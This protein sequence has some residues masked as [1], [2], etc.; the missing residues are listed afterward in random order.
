MALANF[1]ETS[2]SRVGEVWEVPVMIFTVGGTTY[3]GRLLAVVGESHINW[4]K[5]VITL[6]L[7]TGKMVDHWL[8]SFND[9]TRRGKRIA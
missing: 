9:W 8:D 5:T 7:T 2:V 6:D 4:H 1:P 3:E